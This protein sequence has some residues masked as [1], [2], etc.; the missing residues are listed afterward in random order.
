MRT[1]YS[2]QRV[3]EPV[4]GCGEE[5]EEQEESRTFLKRVNRWV[6]RASCQMDQ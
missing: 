5:N 6:D 3:R 1:P 2:D 4:Q